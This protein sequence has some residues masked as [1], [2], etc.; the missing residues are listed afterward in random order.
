MKTET[1]YFI[2]HPRQRLKLRRLTMPSVD[3]D[4]EQLECPM[5]TQNGT[6]T[7]EE[8]NRFLKLPC[9]RLKKNS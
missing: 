9:E 6:A 7:L 8:F 3:K 5:G 1:R 2:T 4:A